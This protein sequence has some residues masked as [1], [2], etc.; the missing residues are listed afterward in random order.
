VRKEW[1]IEWKE[2]QK[3][4]RYP[5][6]KDRNYPY[7]EFLSSVFFVFSASIYPLATSIQ[8]LNSTYVI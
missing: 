5:P 3:I 8:T 2:T 1:E 4:E 6:C 7:K